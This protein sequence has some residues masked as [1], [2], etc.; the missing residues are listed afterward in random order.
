MAFGP[1]TRYIKIADVDPQTWDEGVHHANRIY[2][3][4]MH[5]ICCDNCHS[6]VCCALNHMGYK[7]FRRWNMVIL[8][9]YIFFAGRFDSFWDFLK[10]FGPFTVLFIVV[11]VMKG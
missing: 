2:A 7:G 9:F 10:T 3:G 1:P 8:A 6:H 5:N 4:R 11:M